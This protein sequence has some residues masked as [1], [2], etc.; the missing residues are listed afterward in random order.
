MS[1]LPPSSSIVSSEL[2]AALLLA[3]ATEMGRLGLA[4]PSPAQ[5]LQT[6]GAGRSRAYEL[7]DRLLALLPSLL[8]PQGR[9][10]SEPRAAQ[11]TSA[12]TREVLRFLMQHPGAVCGA[13]ERQRYSDGFRLFVLELFE[14]YP[15][16]ELAPF[17]WPSR[18][19]SG[20]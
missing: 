9:P 10:A 8:R 18:F 15:Q 6:S 17:A 4:H 5:I 13:V 3:A 11:D 1:V 7:K 19:L 12:I 20:R 2:L 16:L 14:R